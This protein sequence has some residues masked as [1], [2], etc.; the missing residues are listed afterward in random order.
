MQAVAVVRKLMKND[1]VLVNM[2]YGN[3]RDSG[4]EKYTQFIGMLLEESDVIF[5]ANGVSNKID[6]RR[7][8]GIVSYLDVDVN[9]GNG[10]TA[11]G[12]F[13]APISGIYYFH[14]QAVSECKEE[15]RHEVEMYLNEKLVTKSYNKHVRNALFKELR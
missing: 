10:M 12:N 9:V 7:D 8:E 14:F 15:V 1:K 3:L 2:E 6:E 5:N 4:S 13:T 11:T